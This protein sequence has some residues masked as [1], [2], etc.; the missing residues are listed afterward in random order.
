MAKTIRER[1][2]KWVIK[3]PSL[4]SKAVEFFR[5][6]Y[7]GKSNYNVLTFLEVLSAERERGFEAGYMSALR[8]I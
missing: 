2:Q 3:N 1:Y 5:L 8:H 6:A 4:T 7:E